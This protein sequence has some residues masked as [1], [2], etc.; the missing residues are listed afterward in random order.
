VLPL[1]LHKTSANSKG[2]L[3]GVM[4]GVTVGEFVLVGVIV[5]VGVIDI[6]GV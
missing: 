3:D 2:S 1:Q 5:D 6:V 4:D